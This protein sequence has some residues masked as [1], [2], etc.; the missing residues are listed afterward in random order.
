MARLFRT[1]HRIDTGVDISSVAFWRQPFHLRDVAFA[2]LRAERPVSWHPALE[3]PGY[4]RSKHHEAGF[5]AVTTAEDISYASRHHELFSS[6]LGQV[7]LR[8]APFR[9]DPNMLV[10]DPPAHDS[11]RRVVSAAF[12][13]SAVAGLEQK[14]ERRSKQIVARAAAQGEF[15]FVRHV[16][17]ELPLRTLADLFALPPSEV[18]SFV[19]AADAYVGSGFPTQLPPGVTM[20]QFYDAQVAYLNNLCLALASHRRR[21]PA[22]DLMTWLV[23]AEIDGRPLS[24][25]QII[26]TMLLLVVAGHD[27]TKQATTL[28]L[29]ALYDN[30]TQR[31][32]LNDDFDGR[33]DAAIDELVRYASPVICFARTARVNTQLHG[34]RIA[35]GDKIALFYCSGNRDESVFTSPGTLDLSRPRAQ[36]V[37]FGGGGVHFCLG[38]AL[39]KV[40][41]KSLFREI[42]RRMPRLEVGEPEFSFSEF[43][44]GV[45]A[46]R[47]RMHR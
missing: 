36:H 12:T 47:V 33:I 40:Q 32:W 24:D 45:T 15:D 28:S 46:L 25:Q 5:W 22:G 35:A 26:S 11:L 29:L 19:V 14:I 16:A 27:T 34:V 30:P 38:S 2:Q 31:D 4:P 18:D 3:T 39:A 44:H 42:L 37:A 13:P 7:S 17:A 43:V 1:E 20:K 9:V 10:L 8:P 23:E 41:L 6:E 21:A